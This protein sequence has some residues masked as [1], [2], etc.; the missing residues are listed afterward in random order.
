[1]NFLNP[2]ALFAL[3]AVAV[4]ILIHIFSRRR[5]P[6]VPFS[7]I[8]FLSPA[9]RRSMVRVNLRRL[10]LLALRVAA[11][12]LVALAFAR[13]VVR[14]SLAAL[15]PAGG[16][17]AVC[18][19][20]DRSY[21]MGLEGEEGEAF[22][23]AKGRLAGILGN[24][25]AGDRVT[26]ALFDTGVEVVYDGELEREVIARALA[27]ERPSWRGTDLR[28]A[29]AFGR[30][31]LERSRREVR[32]LYVLSDFQKSGLGPAGPAAG[33]GGGSPVRALLAPVQS[34]EVANVAVEEVLA[35]RAAIRRGEAA[36]LSVGLRNASEKVEARFPLEI[37]LDGRRVVET[38]IAL[39]PGARRAEEIAVTLDRDGRVRGT[40][41]KAPDRLA[42]DDTRWFALRARSRARALLVGGGGS[43]YLEQALAPAGEGGVIELEKRSERLFTT[44]DLERADILVLGPGLGIE[45]SRAELVER[46]VSNGGTAVVLLLPELESVAKRLS[47][48]ALAF[49]YAEMPRGFFTI[50]RPERAPAFLAP[51]DDDDLAALARVRFARAAFVKGVPRGEMALMFSTGYPFVWIERHGEGTV[52]FAAI[53]PRPE[54]GELVLSPYFLP[55]ARQLVLATGRARAPEEGALVGEDIVRAVAARGEIVCDLPG[56]G[57]YLPEAPREGAAPGA[58][59]GA[60]PGARPRAASAERPVAAPGEREVVV[61]GVDEPGFVTI[62]SGADTLAL[63]AV[64]PDCRRE[65]DLAFLSAG[66]AADSL[67]LSHAMAIGEGSDP[68]EAIRAARQGKEIAVPLLLAAIAALLAEL[69]LAQRR[70]E[71][72]AD[73]G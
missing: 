50:E 56:G 39:A 47:R 70:E 58:G 38:E 45:P 30:E 11:I 4:P 26:I 63:V 40:A 25:E 1:M 6:E 73:V 46:F 53:D 67:G 9:D 16:S 55:L 49:E 24:L 2:L 27:D 7:T 57:V 71:G 51:F 13:P 60:G 23:R 17:R 36:R 3:A 65:S 43:F 68:G 33:S 48:R 37:A 8:R 15:F 61:P 41:R 20:L 54:A 44:E 5:V 28:A 21:S 64:N 52:V 19:L 69:V 29:V 72:G 22:G 62:R 32:E 35:P 10:I 66:A 18:V 42:A 31:T 12:A 59:P 14:G 34:S